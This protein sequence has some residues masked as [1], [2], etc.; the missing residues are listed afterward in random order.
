[1]IRCGFSFDGVDRVRTLV[2][3]TET[4]E[5]HIVPMH[6]RPVRDHGMGLEEGSET[7]AGA[8]GRSPDLAWVLLAELPPGHT[9][10]TRTL[11]E[12]NAECRNKLSKEWRKTARWCIAACCYD[13]LGSA[14]TDTS[15][16][17]VPA[18]APTPGSNGEVI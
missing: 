15:E 17:R 8:A 9:L 7:T 10:R 14:W 1:V 11:G 5:M 13:A 4:S 2:V 18:G 3:M 6:S 16:F 12:A